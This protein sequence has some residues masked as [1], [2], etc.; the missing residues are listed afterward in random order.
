LPL[1][2]APSRRFAPNPRSTLANTF[3]ART[4]PNKRRVCG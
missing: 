3:D 4:E 1:V 2:P